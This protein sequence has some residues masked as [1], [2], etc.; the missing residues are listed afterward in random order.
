MVRSRENNLSKAIA[1][2]SLI[3]KPKIQKKRSP[4]MTRTSMNNLVNMFNITAQLGSEPLK[5]RAA[6]S[7]L[8]KLKKNPSNKKPVKKPV[9]RR[10]MNKLK[11]MKR[12]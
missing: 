9:K 8:K 2:L 6:K 3:S 5:L 7:A 1:S 12:R 10:I 4:Q 11:S